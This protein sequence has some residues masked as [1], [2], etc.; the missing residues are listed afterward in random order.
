LAT[1]D[2]TLHLRLKE[3]TSDRLGGGRDPPQNRKV[4]VESFGI[5]NVF[6]FAFRPVTKGS[7][8]TAPVLKAVD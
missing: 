4:L 8:D 2:W 7:G 5:V 3:G 1:G 6:E